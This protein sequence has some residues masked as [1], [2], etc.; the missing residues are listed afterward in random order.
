MKNQELTD[1]QLL[2]NFIAGDKQAFTL[3]IKRY[4]QSLY[5]YLVRFLGKVSLAEETFQETFLQ[6]HLSA[7]KFDLNRPFKPW[8]YTIASNKARDLMRSQARKP[9]INLTTQD[10]EDTVDLWSSLLQDDATPDT[11]YDQKQQEL[12]VKKI[13]AEMPETPRQILIMA[14]YSQLSYKEMAEAL[15]IP[16]GTV[17]SRLHSAVANFAQRYKQLQQKEKE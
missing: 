13:I 2:G 12:L 6:V 17:K 7:T 16:L 5:N 10:N 1:Q 9:S 3:L 11:I 4:E 14:Y 8:L 15:E